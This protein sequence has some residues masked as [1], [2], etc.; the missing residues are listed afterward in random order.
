MDPKYLQFLF[1]LKKTSV[2]I[3]TIGERPGVDRRVT[4]VFRAVNKKMIGKAK[5][6]KYNRMDFKFR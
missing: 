4:K 5:Q 2:N 3:K 6:K 1:S